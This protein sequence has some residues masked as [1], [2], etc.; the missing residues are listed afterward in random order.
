MPVFFIKN[1]IVLIPGDVQI[2][3]SG[4]KYVLGIHLDIAEACEIVTDKYQMA[5]H[6]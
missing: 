1:N 3:Y 6:K 2:F 5:S 4:Y